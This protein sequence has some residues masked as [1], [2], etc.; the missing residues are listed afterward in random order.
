MSTSDDE[1]RDPTAP[2]PLPEGPEEAADEPQPAAPTPAADDTQVVGTGETQAFTPPSAPAYGQPTYST[3][4]YSSPS[5][6][7]PSYERPEWSSSAPFPA[8]AAPPPYPATPA[9]HPG[10]TPGYPPPPAA[11]GPAPYPYAAPPA[12]PVGPVG[13]VPGSPYVQPANNSSALALTIVAAASVLLCGGVLVIPALI[14]GIVG[15]TKQSTDPEGSRRASRNG[16][17]AYAIGAAVSVLLVIGLIAFLIAAGSSSGD[18][19]TSYDGY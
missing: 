5:Y 3:P 13:H 19:S 17:W 9:P 12:G 14:F 10:G 1:Y 6:E 11:G 4:S 15:L 8:P 2:P 16:W 18:V 7:Q